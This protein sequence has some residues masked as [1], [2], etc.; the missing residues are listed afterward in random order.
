MFSRLYEAEVAKADALEKVE[1]VNRLV[2][3]GRLAAGVAHEINN[4]LAVIKESAGYI[5]DL[6]DAGGDEERNGE[7]REPAEAIT[8][9][10]RR[11]AAISRQLLSFARPADRCSDRV[12]L[13]VLIGKVL[14]F[15]DKEAEFRNVSISTSVD[16]DARFVQADPGKLQQVLLN[17]VIN[18]FDAMPEG[19]QIA[20]RVS[21]SGPETIGI[22]VADT[23]HGIPPEALKSVFEPFFTTKSEGAGTGLG[24]SITYGIVNRMGG[25]ISVESKVGKGAVFRVELPVERPEGGEE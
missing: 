25:A 8:E 10:V 7:F 22:E 20:I 17:L 19:G 1:D 14:R 18:A 15:H 13:E 4:P 21:K 11:C 23:G 2:S 9:S 24:L 12:D 16:D 6:L 5:Q 3:L